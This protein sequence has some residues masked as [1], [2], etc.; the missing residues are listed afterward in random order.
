M[1]GNE[2]ELAEL[3]R[4]VARLT[5]EA[6]KNEDAWKRAQARE[7][8]LLEA[9]KLATLLERLT[10]G[11]R[12]GYQLD[13]AT[14]VLADHDHEIRH[15]LISQG[16]RVESL[17]GVS[18]VDTLHGLAPQLRSSRPWLG[19]FER[20]D[21]GLL[22]GNQSGLRSVALLPLTRHE[23]L[24]GSLNMGSR[25]AARFT[26]ALATD[27]LHHLAVIAAFALE[28]SINRSR[29]VRSGFTDVLTG[30]HNRRYLQ[31]RLREELARSSRERTALVCLMVDVDHFK[32]VNDRYG[33]L[34][35]DEVLSQ[36]AQCVDAVVR[37]SDVSARYGGEEF[38]ILLPGT[39]LSAGQALA[40]RIRR[41]VAAEPFRLRVSAQSI[42]VTVSIGV[43]EY[44]PAERDEDLKVAGERLIARADVALYEAKAR[45]RNLVA[46]AANG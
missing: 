4:R 2:F 11:L 43:A 34:A 36:L 8:D 28:N 46:L 26:R 33:H 38:V 5:E 30:W 9:D 39:D 7:M 3:R 41:A 42:E 29:L 14:L 45:G 25:D 32:R 10:E 37:S 44:R 20:S 22:F 1:A 13:A 40:E 15:L 24:V 21:H 6:R 12:A 23:R 16:E 35:G 19:P 17:A 27:F 18:F 31:A